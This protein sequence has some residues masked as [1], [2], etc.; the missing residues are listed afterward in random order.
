MRAYKQF[1]PTLDK[2]RADDRICLCMQKLKLSLL[3]PQHSVFW[4]YQDYHYSSSSR[5]AFGGEK[6][7]AAAAVPQQ[8]WMCATGAAVGQ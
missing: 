3:G 5:S 8:V 1:V 6:L 7:Q 4:L 2:D